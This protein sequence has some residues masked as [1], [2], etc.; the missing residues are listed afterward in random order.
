[1]LEINGIKLN[2]DLSDYEMMEKFTKAQE[3]LQEQGKKADN[4]KNIAK[5]MKK[6]VSMFRNVFVTLFGEGTA[7]AIVE[8]QKSA[9]EWAGAFQKLVEYAMQDSQTF[10]DQMNSILNLAENSKRDERR[11][12]YVESLNQLDA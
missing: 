1:M 3:D 2:F 10:N 5:Q 9:K 6:Y 7:N 12:A 8:N 11:T 4:E